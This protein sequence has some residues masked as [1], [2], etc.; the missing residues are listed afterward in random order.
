MNQT[1]EPPA[2]PPWDGPPGGGKPT[3]L[4]GFPK[5]LPRYAVIDRETGEIIELEFF[6]A[7][8]KLKE[9]LGRKKPDGTALAR[10]FFDIR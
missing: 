9:V 3:N 10:N 2:P 6:L 7:R 4:Q 1:P 5:K 8:M